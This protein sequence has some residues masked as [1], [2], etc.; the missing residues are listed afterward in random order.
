MWDGNHFAL[1]DFYEE[2]NW[3]YFGSYFAVSQIHGLALRI[4]MQDLGLWMDWGIKIV[5][6]E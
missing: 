2:Y 5:H 6:L 1:N 4:K 3:V